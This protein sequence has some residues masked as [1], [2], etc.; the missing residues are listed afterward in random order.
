MMKYSVMRNHRFGLWILL[1]FALFPMVMKAQSKQRIPIE[2][3]WQGVIEEQNGADTLLYIAL[4]E[5]LYNGPIPLYC[6]SLP[7]YDDAVKVEATLLDVK[8]AQLA[9]EEIQ[10]AK[11]CSYNADFQIEARSIRARDESLISLCIVPFRQTGNAVEK[12]LSAT[13]LVTLT[14]DMS[15][16]KAN[17]EYAH[18][19][20]MASGNWYKVGLSE[21]GIYKLTY[22]ELKSLGVNVENVDPRQIRVYHN[23]G[24]VLPEANA[25]ARHDDLVEIP[26][27]VAGE[28]DGRFDKND[29]ILFY[30]RGPVCWKYN[31]SK[32]AFEH[33]QNPYDDYAYAFV[34]TGL[35]TGKR[36]AESATISIAAI[37]F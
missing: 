26:I 9:P 3:H 18:R 23:G 10:V 29:Y 32:R 28:A 36:I 4:D 37:L 33:I 7:I 21:T 25:E 8:T 35:G 16:Q 15:A 19:S 27:Y 20:A 34:V 24:G 22:E 13:L 14:P 30:G 1:V 2:L 17:H 5:G 11:N 6:K 31:T 12:L